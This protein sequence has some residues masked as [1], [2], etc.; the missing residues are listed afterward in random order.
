[1]PPKSS[2]RL[3]IEKEI[4]A[5]DKIPN[6]E[7][8]LDKAVG[9]TLAALPAKF[10]PVAK[11]AT[12]TLLLTSDK[13]VQ[14][15]NRDWRGKNKPTNVL[16]FPQFS[17]K[18]LAALGAGKTPVYIGDVAVAAPFVMDE[19]ARD[20]KKVLDHLT[21]LTIHSLLHLFGYDHIED[22]QAAQMEKMEIKI[23]A[24]LGLPDPYN[25]P[26]GR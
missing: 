19:A 5:W 12:F 22:K 3:T 24:K 21:H 7:K 1:M 23:M 2:T 20:S 18:I 11:R 8:R 6:L 9:A 10:Q 4:K 15:L 13:K 14:G 25:P 26:K 17:P 16:S